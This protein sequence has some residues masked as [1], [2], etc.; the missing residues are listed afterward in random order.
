M[1]IITLI[2]TR[3]EAIKMVP[4]IKDINHTNIENVVVSSGQ[5]EELLSDVFKLYDIIPKYKLNTL[6]N[7]KSL[8]EIISFI[9]INFE[10]ILDIEKP[11]LVLVHGDTTT[12]MAGA[13]ASFNKKIKIAHIEAGLRSFNLESPFPEEM[14]RI[15]ID[16][17]AY[18]HF[19]PT[20]TAKNNLIK[21]GIKPHNIFVVGNTII[22]L[23]KFNLKQDIKLKL[24]DIDEKRLILLTTHRRENLGKNMKS[25][26]SAV[27]ILLEKYD[28]IC[29]VFPMHPNPLIKKIADE[30]LKKNKRLIITKPF[31]TIEFNKLEQLADIVMTDS[32][33]IQEECVFIGKPTI[34]L[35]T[36]TERSDGLKSN[37]LFLAGVN[38]NDIVK[39]F[40]SI[41]TDNFSNLKKYKSSK[42]YG[43]GR[44]SERII[45]IIQ[46]SLN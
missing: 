32:G 44:S 28:N 21:Q 8:N 45:K 2:G 34:V 25:I 1:K 29:I 10:K 26:F 12:A 5:H 42:I 3:P 22:D 24:P 4:I 7:C 20:V 13:L 6:K 30:T 39:T 46:K 27:N 31:N 16:S 36:E 33:G 11:D 43:D 18:L 17:I 37:N 23:V 9:L 38:T 19:A 15:F 35:R 14:N 41:A 40:D